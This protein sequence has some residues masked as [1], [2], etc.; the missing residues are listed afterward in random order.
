[1]T[2][3]SIAILGGAAWGLARLWHAWR[4]PRR[5]AAL[6]RLRR[7]TWRGSRDVPIVWFWPPEG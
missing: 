4:H 6:A 1:V 5:T 3:L 7:E 2:R